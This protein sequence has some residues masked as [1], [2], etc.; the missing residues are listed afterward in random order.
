MDDAHEFIPATIEAL[1]EIVRH[2]KLGADAWNDID[3]A[4]LRLLLD[5]ATIRLGNT[6]LKPATERKLRKRHNRR[7]RQYTPDEIK[8]H[9]RAELNHAV[10]GKRVYKPP[11]CE[12]CKRYVPPYLLQGHH[13][14]YSRPLEVKWLCP[15]CHTAEHRDE[16]MPLIRFVPPA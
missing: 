5:A 12:G 13:H 4:L 10:H 3:A 8:T 1:W 16:K 2:N 11:N 6:P 9:A 14:D 7:R 15:K